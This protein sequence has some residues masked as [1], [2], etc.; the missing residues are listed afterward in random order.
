MPPFADLQRR[1]ST[2]LRLQDQSI[3]LPVD[4]EKLPG[5]LPCSVRNMTHKKRELPLEILAAK[6][7]RAIRLGRI[8]RKRRAAVP[9]LLLDCDVLCASAK[10]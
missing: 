7:H 2:L 5:N 8:R 9:V 6:L 3:T 10:T 4:S 1:Q